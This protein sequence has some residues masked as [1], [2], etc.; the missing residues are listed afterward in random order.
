MHVTSTQTTPR[1]VTDAPPIQSLH[2][3]SLPTHKMTDIE[4]STNPTLEAD[5]GDAGSNAEDLDEEVRHSGS[6]VWLL[7]RQLLSIIQ[8]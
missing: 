5:A 7:S 1:F 6:A 2:F 8:Y 3:S 4:A